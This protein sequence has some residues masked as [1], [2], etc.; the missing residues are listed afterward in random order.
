M[1]HTE[2]R[3]RAEDRLCTTAQVKHKRKRHLDTHGSEDDET[4]PLDGEQLKFPSSLWT[5][6]GENEVVMGPV[7]SESTHPHIAVPSEG[8]KG[9]KVHSLQELKYLQDLIIFSLFEV[10]E[11]E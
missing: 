8:F 6:T 11:R 4:D 7:C 9:E 3:Q 5:Q 10:G 2:I 1:T